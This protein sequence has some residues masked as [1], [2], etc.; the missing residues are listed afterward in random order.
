MLSGCGFRSDFREHRRIAD[1][2]QGRT[3]LYYRPGD[4]HERGPFQPGGCFCAR[5]VV[6]QTPHS[7]VPVECD[8]EEHV[9]YGSV[10][11]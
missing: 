3:E 4:A 7:T 1:Q 2:I 10:A 9:V 6:T 8:A 5:S 11:G